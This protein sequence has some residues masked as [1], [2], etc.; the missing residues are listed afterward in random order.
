[1]AWPSLRARALS[2]FCACAVS[3]VVT[4]LS[5]GPADADGVSMTDGVTSAP[6]SILLGTAAAHETVRVRDGEL[7]I[8]PGEGGVD[9]VIDRNDR[10]VGGAAGRG[11]RAVVEWSPEIDH[12]LARSHCHGPAAIGLRPAV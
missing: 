4:A 7:W 12:G 8:C 3:I 9:P 2:G 6:F 10:V 11:L 5:A 1:M